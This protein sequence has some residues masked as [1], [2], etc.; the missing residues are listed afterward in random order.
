MSRDRDADAR[1]AAAVARDDLATS[2]DADGLSLAVLQVRPRCA[3]YSGSGPSRTIRPPIVG[4]RGSGK[5][6]VLSRLCRQLPDDHV[7]IRV[8]VVGMDDPSDPSVLGSVALGAALD[9]AR[10]PP[11]SPRPGGGPV[12]AAAPRCIALATAAIPSAILRTACEEG[13]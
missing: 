10:V 3:W 13:E 4:A 8:P 9:V 2:L 12:V 7:A 11:Q 5:S 1:D 6:S